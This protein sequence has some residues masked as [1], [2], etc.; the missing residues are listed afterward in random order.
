MGETREDRRRREREAQ[1]RREQEI[2]R[3][4]EEPRLPS[5]EAPPTG[6]IV[7]TPRKPQPQPKKG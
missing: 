4:T 3:L 6:K 2:D 7:E 5:F 1:R